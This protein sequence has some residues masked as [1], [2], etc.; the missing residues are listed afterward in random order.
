MFQPRVW[1]RALLV[2]HAQHQRARSGGNLNL[3][4]P[5]IGGEKKTTVLSKGPKETHTQQKQ[6]DGVQKRLCIPL[7]RLHGTLSDSSHVASPPVLGMKEQTTAGLT[8]FCLDS[9]LVE[10]GAVSAAELL[11]LFDLHVDLDGHGQ[12]IR[13][14]Q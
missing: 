8:M 9:P 6:T 2:P 1:G 10:L 3:N 13:Q 5:V 11:D 14:H 12:K 4:L 7:A